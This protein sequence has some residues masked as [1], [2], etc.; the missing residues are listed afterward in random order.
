MSPSHRLIVIRVG[1][2]TFSKDEPSTHQHSFNPACRTSKVCVK[3]PTS[4]DVGA[5]V[6]LFSAFTGC[7]VYAW[8]KFNS[9]ANGGDVDE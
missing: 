8:R 5:C 3:S 6:V 4:A 9:P 7:T 1:P 2:V